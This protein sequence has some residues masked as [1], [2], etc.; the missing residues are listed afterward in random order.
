[1]TDTRESKSAKPARAGHNLDW[2]LLTLVLLAPIVTILL[3]VVATE[4][5]EGELILTARG[6][7]VL[8]F[9]GVTV[10]PLDADG[11]CR[12][13]ARFHF[14]SRTTQFG[15]IRAETPTGR[16]DIELP[17]SEVVSKAMR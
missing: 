8:E 10:E 14:G 13:R 17:A 2:L 7:R 3:I 9:H 11:L 16:L 1:M 6:C 5:D 15:T 12:I 4:F